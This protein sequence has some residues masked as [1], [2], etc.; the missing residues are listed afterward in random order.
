[1]IYPP[2][3]KSPHVHITFHQEQNIKRNYVRES[4]P[5]RKCTVYAGAILQSWIHT[6][7]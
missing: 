3:L 6:F 5:A 4:V 2:T 7:I 1:M